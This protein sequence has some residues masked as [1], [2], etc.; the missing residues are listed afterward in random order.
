MVVKKLNGVFSILSALLLLAHSI[1]AGLLLA[2]AVGYSPLYRQLGHML[3]LAMGLHALFCALLFFFGGGGARPYAAHSVKTLAQ[4]GAGLALLVLLHFHMGDY[5]KRFSDGSFIHTE[6]TPVV[7]I[8]ELLFF[9][10]LCLHTAISVPRAA[11]TFG[12]TPSGKAYDRLEKGCGA[13]C[14][15]LAVF[16]VGCL[17]RYFWGGNA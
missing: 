8:C 12:L 7:F 15:L 10:L 17:V 1:P 11:L 16:L 9:L 3:L 2:G 6:K 13:A 4:R 14:L 5:T